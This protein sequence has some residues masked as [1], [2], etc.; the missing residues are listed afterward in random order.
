MSPFARISWLLALSRMVPSGRSGSSAWM[1][2]SRID[3]PLTGAWM[4]SSRGWAGAH[5]RLQSTGSAGTPARAS[6]A[7]LLVRRGDPVLELRRMRSAGSKRRPGGRGYGEWRHPHGEAFLPGAGKDTGQAAISV[8]EGNGPGRCFPL[9]RA[10]NPTQIG[11]GV[12]NPFRCS[13]FAA[14][15]GRAALHRRART[16]RVGSTRTQESGRPPDA[17][18]ETASGEK[19]TGFVKAA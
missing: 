3:Q 1:N 15:A 5:G 10:R 16:G 8:A 12:T 14:A 18:G 2:W 11:F 4:K 7:D 13:A 19:K 17:S 6:V 9:D